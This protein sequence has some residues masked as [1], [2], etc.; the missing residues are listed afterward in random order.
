MIEIMECGIARLKC[1]VIPV[2]YPKSEINQPARDPSQVLSFPDAN[3]S[4]GVGRQIV[5]SGV[6]HQ[7]LG[8]FKPGGASSNQKG[9]LKKEGF[10]R[11]FFCKIAKKDIANRSLAFSVA[12][13]S[14]IGP[15]N[16]VPP[17]I[18]LVFLFL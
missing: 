6:K 9:D 11:S 14:S 7:R 10:R 13:A 3:A 15:Q 17:L 5:A 1:G 12:S 18:E 2:K 4:N 8:T 16:R